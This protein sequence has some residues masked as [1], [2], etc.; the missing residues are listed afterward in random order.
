M[1]R[2]VNPTA[3]GLFLLFV[4]ATL[5][6]S[7]WAAKRTRTRS[8]FYTAGG[9][10]TALQNGAA[11]A[12]DYISASAFLGVT[13]LFYM[14][15][16]DAMIIG[17]AS[18]AAW[19]LM[20][21]LSE[22][23]RNLGK[24]TFIDV[25]SFRLAEKPIRVFFASSSLLIILGYLISQMVAAGALVEVLFGLPYELAEII[26]GVL[27]V[28]YV[29]F[30]GM[31]AT[32]WVQIIKAILLM[33]GI[34]IM[35]LILMLRVD[36]DVN[37]LV[38]Q[39]VLI[40]EDKTQIT[41]AGILFSG[42]EPLTVVVTMMFGTLGLPHIL[43]RLF[44]VKDM[45]TARKSVLH[46]T[47]FI[48]Y[49]LLLLPVLGFATIVFVS[50]NQEYFS[51]G[52]MIGGTNMAAIHLSHALGGELLV[53][54]ISAIAFATLLAVVAGVAIAGAASIAHDLYASV[55]CSN[56]IDPKHELR[57]SRYC[58]LVIGLLSVLLGIAFKNQNITFIVSM[59]M[60]IAAS[61]NFPVIF[62]SLYW[63]RLTTS[64]ALAG[65]IVGMISALLFIISG[66][67]VWVDLFG[68]EKAVFPYTYP[69]LFSMTLAFITAWLVS[70]R[71]QSP[72]AR[73]DRERFLP[74]LIKSELGTEA[75]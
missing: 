59:P 36:F 34:T 72:Q 39:A 16:V 51:Q 14:G 9:R 4:A 65:G 57:V 40:H 68:F 19:P 27:V 69:G 33:T 52:N 62:L 49:F 8:E 10:I 7:Y 5:C 61:T 3:I 55:L 23:I 1:D 26:V 53:A 71:D 50:G 13:A 48:A 42:L 43:M 11:I 47:S 66:K 25:V 17:I 2:A 41:Q 45:S 75:S 38:Q 6:I 64:G 56:K 67:F 35:F 73:L 15:Y 44:T 31:L 63:K 28:V 74:Q 58:T 22:Q 30:G 70:I 29:A 60:V 24:Y 54:F 37:G 12:G 46:A 18:L 20:L 21:I 32:T